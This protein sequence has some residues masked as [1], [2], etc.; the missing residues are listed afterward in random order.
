MDLRKTIWVSWNDSI[1]CLTINISEPEIWSHFC[2]IL[3][4]DNFREHSSLILIDQ[5]SDVAHRSSDYQ[6]AGRR[7]KRKRR[8][9]NLLSWTSTEN[10]P[11]EWRR[12]LYRSQIPSLFLL[13]FFFCVCAKITCYFFYLIDITTGKTCKICSWLNKQVL[14]ILDVKII[15]NIEYL[16]TYYTNIDEIDI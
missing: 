2:H 3:N 15:I 6:S 4:L 13:L 1:R 12:H 14:N 8:Q 9:R 5:V 10:V 7:K 16:D 11:N